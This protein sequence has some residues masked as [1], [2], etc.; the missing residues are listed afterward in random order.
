MRVKKIKRLLDDLGP[1]SDEVA[2]ALRAAG[3]KG[4]DGEPMLCPIANYLKENGV[5][6]PFVSPSDIWV[7]AKVKMFRNNERVWIRTPLPVREFI[8]MLDRGD[9]RFSDLIDTGPLA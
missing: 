4:Y 1:T 9:K 6:T 5:A 7:T 3:V 8:R 2:K